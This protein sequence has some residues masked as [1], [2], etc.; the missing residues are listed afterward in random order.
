MN[1]KNNFDTF[2]ELDSYARVVIKNPNF[3]KIISGAVNLKHR[4]LPD[5]FINWVCNR[6]CCEDA[7]CGQNIQCCEVM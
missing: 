4:N 5:K 7:S 3:L 6:G 1:T 2:F